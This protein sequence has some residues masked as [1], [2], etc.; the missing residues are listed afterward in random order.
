MLLET[1]L[2]FNKFNENLFMKLIKV[3]EQIKNYD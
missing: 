3:L 1:G 2:T